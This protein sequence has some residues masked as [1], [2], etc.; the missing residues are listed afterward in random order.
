MSVTING[1]GVISGVTGI[2]D[3]GSDKVGYQPA[4]IGAVA[5]TVHDKLRESVSVFDFMTHDQIA[6]VRSGT[7]DVTFGLQ[8]AINN[9]TA[10]SVILLPK[11]EYI[12]TGVTINK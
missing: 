6:N 4:D 12:I 5:S 10:G 8:A 7:G 2:T 11:G 3:F 9:A 1:N